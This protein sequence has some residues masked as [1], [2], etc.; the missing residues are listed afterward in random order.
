MNRIAEW[1]V[2][3]LTLAA[4]PGPAWT[5]D[6]ARLRA[7][8]PPAGAIWVETIDLTKMTQRRGE[9]RAGRSIRDLPISL[10]GSTYPH[11]IGTR[12][13]SEFVID[14]H[15]QALRFEAMVGLDDAVRQGVGSVVFEVWADDKLVTASGLMRAGDAARRLSADLAGAHVLTLLLD[16]G[17]DTSNDDEAAWG[18]ATI[19]LNPGAP[20][21]T[22]L[23]AP[24]EPAPLI[25]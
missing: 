13:I 6:T 18:G 14:L 8:E 22:P 9:P 11:G 17:G 1:F 25:A 16:D 12:S 4:I 5:Q 21:P 23:V 10:G 2:L 15:G 19:Y 7:A 20:P 24:A 3:A